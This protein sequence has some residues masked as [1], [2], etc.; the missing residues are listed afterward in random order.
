M[1]TEDFI[2]STDHCLSLEDV[3]ALQRTITSLEYS[4]Y[5]LV[6]NPERVSK[7]QRNVIQGQSAK[8]AAR[9]IPLMSRSR[10]ALMEND[11]DEALKYVTLCAQLEQLKELLEMV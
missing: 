6:A 5:Y 9:M 11:I 1:Y 4:T 8:T 10:K 7:E 2:L 3:D